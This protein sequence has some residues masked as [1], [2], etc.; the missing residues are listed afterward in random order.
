L[1]GKIG[2]DLDRPLSLGTAIDSIL[3][4]DENVDIG[5]RLGVTACPRA[6]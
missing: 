4:N 5:I 6:E 3:Q 2:Y 1:K